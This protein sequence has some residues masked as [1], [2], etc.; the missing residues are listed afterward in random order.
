[1]IY[2]TCETCL[3]EKKSDVALELSSSLFFLFL[4][5]LSLSCT[6]AFPLI[7]KGKARNPIRASFPNALKPLESNS[8]P[9]DTLTKDLGSSPSLALFV[10]PTTNIE[11]VTRAASN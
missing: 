9:F 7:Y 11:L 8:T 3:S 1:M 2:R 5:F 10:T 4:L 6:P